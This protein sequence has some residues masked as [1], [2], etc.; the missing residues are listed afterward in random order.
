MRNVLFNRVRIAAVASLAALPAGVV[1]AQ[2][3]E[4]VVA[5]GATG[6]GACSGPFCASAGGGYVEGRVARSWLGGYGGLNVVGGGANAVGGLHLRLGPDAWIARPALR[7]GLL[8]G[9]DLF[10]TGGLGLDVGRAFGGQFT[11]DWSARGG[12]GYAV[13]HFGAYYRF[14]GRW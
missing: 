13:V 5:G 1:P 14:G 8:K 6:V 11:V 12:V 2:A 3:Q 7:A 9:D 10:G 4:I